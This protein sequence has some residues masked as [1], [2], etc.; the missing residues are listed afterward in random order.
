MAQCLWRILQSRSHRSYSVLQ[1]PLAW[2]GLLLTAQQPSA[3][4][5]PALQQQQ[6]LRPLASNHKPSMPLSKQQLVEL[7]FRVNS[8]S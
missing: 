5:E 2:T 3:H 1:S 4:A 6:L 8:E 7:R